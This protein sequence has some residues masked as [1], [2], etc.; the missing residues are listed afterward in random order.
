M[1]IQQSS[2]ITQMGKIPVVNGQILD[3]LT[4]AISQF[5]DHLR[6]C[7]TCP[8][9]LNPAYYSQIYVVLDTA[10]RCLGSEA[11]TTLEAETRERLVQRLEDCGVFL[12]DTFPLFT[13]AVWRLCCKLSS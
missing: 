7:L 2:L 13:L 4:V 9:S 5:S 1:R 8:S 6:E 11:V 12:C 10:D 3:K